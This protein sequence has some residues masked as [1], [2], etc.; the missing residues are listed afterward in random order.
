MEEIRRIFYL[1]T[2]I[3][4]FQEM[5]REKRFARENVLRVKTFWVWFKFIFL[6]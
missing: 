6:I 3:D 1:L 2:T 5:E 4:L